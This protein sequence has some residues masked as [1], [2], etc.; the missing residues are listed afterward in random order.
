MVF[1]TEGFFEAAIE[2]WLE[3]HLNPRLTVFYKAV[4]IICKSLVKYNVICW[5]RVVR[6]FILA[7]YCYNLTFD[8]GIHFWISSVFSII[9]L[10]KDKISK[11]K[12]FSHIWQKLFWKIRWHNFKSNI[13]F[14][15][16]WFIWFISRD[17]SLKQSD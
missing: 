10:V 6:C 8:N 3:W 14:W 12:F 16:V 5:L 11:S 17:I 9:F 7:P 13:Y 1:T 15:F 4:K 2:S